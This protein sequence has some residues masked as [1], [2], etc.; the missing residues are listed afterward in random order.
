MATNP[1]ILT[2]WPWARLGSYKYV[3]LAPFVVHSICS[4]LTKEENGRDLTNFLIFPFLLWRM[5]HN[6]IWISLSRYRTAKGNNRILDKTIEFEQVD[7]ESNWAGCDLTLTGTSSI[8]V[9]FGYVTYIDFMNNLGHCNFELIP[10]KLFT[11]FPP[12]KYIMYT[13]TYRSMAQPDRYSNNYPPLL[14]GAEN[15]N[16]WKFRKK[17]FL[18]RDAFE[19]DAVENWSS[20][21]KC[22]LS[23]PSLNHPSTNLPNIQEGNLVL[24]HK[25]FASSFNKEQTT[26]MDQTRTAVRR[27]VRNAHEFRRLF[28]RQPRQRIDRII[29]E[30]FHAPAINAAS[31][32]LLEE[33]TNKSDTE[34]QEWDV[35][36]SY[37]YILGRMSSFVNASNQ[38]NDATPT[39]WETRAN[40]AELRQR[41][42]KVKKRK[43]ARRGVR[44]PRRQSD[45]QKFPIRTERG[46]VSQP[47][48]G[49]RF[50]TTVAGGN[51]FSEP[52]I[53]LATAPTQ[54]GRDSRLREFG[55]VLKMDWLSSNGAQIDYKGKKVKIRMP[56]GKEIVIKGQ[57]QTQKFLNI[58]QAKK[59]LRKD[60]KADASHKGLGCML[61]E[62]GKV[63][64]YASW[65]LKE[66]EKELNRRQ[67]RWLEL[68]KDYVG[69]IL[70]HP[71]KASVV[72]DALSSK[73]RL[74]MLTTPE[75]LVRELEEME[76]EVKS[77]EEKTNEERESLTEN[78][79]NVRKMR[80][81]L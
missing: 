77:L 56:N 53:I 52:D 1:G 11:I 33:K 29:S 57:R 22:F 36:R 14:H 17:I 60:S 30:K 35:T 80:R 78:K 23:K 13:P 12:L 62:H 42:S 24:K 79:S 41:V 61:M 59:L 54:L 19:W 4:Y 32:E 50:A 25:S 81:E 8:V 74:K 73:E 51:S 28:V 16:D 45:K 6:Q 43:R 67:G 40:P 34:F 72:A 48:V 18:Q 10:R 47:A 68:M 49:T 39:Y 27:R 15:Y 46:V 26:S 75:E 76:I 55:V 7:R 44:K 38:H 2:D 63:V 64:A 3:V 20:P 58:A 37:V 31:S 9:V 5:L 66:Y 21:S 70:Y 71:G 65:Q 69:E